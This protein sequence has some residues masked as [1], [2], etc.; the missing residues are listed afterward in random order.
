V[1]ARGVDDDDRDAGLAAELRE[2]RPEG[3]GDDA[4]GALLDRLEID[5]QHPARAG[6]GDRA[7]ERFDAGLDA[8]GR[9]RDARPVE[10]RRALAVNGRVADRAGARGGV[11][12]VA[13]LEADDDGALL[14]VAPQD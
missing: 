8:V 4:A 2:L 11:A 9:V 10:V 6:G 14:A 12:D 13:A 3:V 1:G 7:A 5:A